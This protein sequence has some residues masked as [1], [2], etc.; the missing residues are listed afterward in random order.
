M[1]VFYQM[2]SDFKDKGILVP[3]VYMMFGYDFL[4]EFKEA[5]LSFR[6]GDDALR[7]HGENLAKSGYGA[8]LLG[9]LDEPRARE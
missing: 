2:H 5:G 8:Y 6:Y 1:L 4:N 3:R 9:L 7:A